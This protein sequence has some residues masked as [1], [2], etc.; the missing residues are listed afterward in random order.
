MSHKKRTNVQARKM[1]ARCWEKA[2]IIAHQGNVPMFK[3]AHA[4]R[5]V[6]AR[7]HSWRNAHP[8]SIRPATGMNHRRAS[9]AA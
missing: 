3:A 7:L 5:E 4:E 8:L 2:K 1:Q 9:D 6:A